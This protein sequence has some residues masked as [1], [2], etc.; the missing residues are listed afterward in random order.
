MSSAHNRLL[1]VRVHIAAT[2]KHEQ[3]VGRGAEPSPARLGTQFANVRGPAGLEEEEAKLALSTG[4]RGG[5]GGLPTASE[6]AQ[7]S[8]HKKAY[9]P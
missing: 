3:A 1:K 8:V 2:K 5:G 4:A 9:Q 6:T 7:K